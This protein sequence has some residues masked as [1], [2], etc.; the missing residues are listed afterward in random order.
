MNRS[1]VK[2]SIKV[3]TPL[4]F[5]LLLQN[6]INITDAIF[7]GRVGEVEL[8]AAAL[9]GV[10]YMAI[11]YVGFGF[12]TGMQALV[13]RR[14]GEER[15]ERIGVIVWQ[16]ML[17]LLLTALVSI[18][19]TYMF[20]PLGFKFA[21]S[22]DAVFTAT[23]DYLDWRILGIIP[24]FLVVVYRAMFVGIK[25]TKVLVYSSI[26]MTAA[27]VML[28][29]L[30]IFGV[31][32]IVAP[33]G[34]KGA[35]IASSLSEIVGLIFYIAYCQKIDRQKYQLFKNYNLEL[36]VIKRILG[37]SSWTMLQYFL[38]VFVWLIFFIGIEQ[39]G[40]RALAI[41]N[42]IRSIGMMVF[43]VVSAFSTSASTLAGNAMGERKPKSV[44]EITKINILLCYA[45]M[46]PICATIVI[47]P[48]SILSIFTNNRELIEASVST[49]Y[50]LALYSLVAVASNILFNVIIGT[51]NTKSSLIIEVAAVAVYGILITMIILFKPPIWLCWSAEMVYWGVILVMG[52][53]YIRRYKWWKKVI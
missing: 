37:V 27:N 21:I 45:F 19:A 52:Y 33:Q 16:S 46:V 31:E 17:F 22:S 30:L 34:I 3:A 35:A 15:F 29:Y 7:L 14:N 23:M 26:A 41:S 51:G 28:N 11:Y 36:D 18:G 39:L 20:A 25:Q 13:A 53:A 5:S 9:A 40:E 10:F 12:G 1:I 49:M 32:G 50:V 4:L 44:L 43:V 47:F 24:A 42:L 8:G 2:D 6:L 38:T 48:E